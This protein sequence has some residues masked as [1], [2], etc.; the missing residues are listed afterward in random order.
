VN[1]TVTDATNGAARTTYTIKVA[2]PALVIQ[3]AV[4]PNGTVG[5][6]YTVAFSATGGAPPYTF[7]A[8]GQP[9][10]MTM[11]ASG[12]FTGTPIAPGNFPV[13]V[14][15]KDGNGTTTSKSFPITISLPSSPPL[16]FAGINTTVNAVQQPRVAVSLASPYPVEVPV[17]LTLTF[18]AD[19]GPPDPAVVFSTGG[20]TTTITNPRRITEWCDRR[21]H[22]D[23]HGRGDDHD[24]CPTHGRRSGR[25][26]IAGADPY[27]AHRCRGPG[28]RFGD[29]H[30]DIAR[31]HDHGGRIRDRSR[32]A[33]GGIRLQRIEPWDHNA[34][35]HGGHAVCGLAGRE[36]AA[37]RAFGSQF[38][39][40]QPLSVNGT[41]TSVTSVT[42]TLNNKVGASNTVTVTLQ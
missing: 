6:V 30:E 18:Q 31:L 28:D 24:H 25:D 13:V 3:Q 26:T 29:R 35:G 27:C 10:T 15:V 22:P 5:S 14:T 16:N 23:R 11:A 41:N 7:S 17:T 40:T 32:D 38:T 8:T 33:N 21:R 1:A 4:V 42:V 19:S 2:P 34:D 12:L 37:I 39:Y 9:S 20:T 36:L